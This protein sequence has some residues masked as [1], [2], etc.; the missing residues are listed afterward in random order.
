MS[1]K[2]QEEIIYVGDV[3]KGEWNVLH[4]VDARSSGPRLWVMRREDG[5]TVYSIS[6][7]IRKP[8]NYI[9]RKAD[10]S[11]DL[12]DA[13]TRAWFKPIWEDPQSQAS[14]PFTRV[15]QFMGTVLNNEP[16]EDEVHQ[17]LALIAAKTNGGEGM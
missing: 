6:N 15:S 2:K 9:K 17:M 8:F 13:C 12:I 1:A 10:Y 3:T 5:E 7:E 11:N 4:I 14:D 16:N